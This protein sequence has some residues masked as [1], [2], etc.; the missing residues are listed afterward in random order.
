MSSAAS[1]LQGQ[2]SNGAIAH[3]ARLPSELLKRR[4][5]QR[6]QMLVVQAVSYSLI[7]SVLLVY[8]YAGTISIII[9]SAYFLTG[10]G[11]VATFVVLSEAH[12]NDRFEDHYLT[13]YMVGGHVALQLGFL[14]A[15]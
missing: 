12:V 3:V 15:W 14:L 7:A 11:L 8:C 6:R 9:P 4:V 2:G 5:G 13:I 10:T 1:L